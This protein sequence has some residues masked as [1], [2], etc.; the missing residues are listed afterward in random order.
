MVLMDLPGAQLE[1]SARLQDVIDA[2]R[3]TKK[4]GEITFTL[5]V[6]V[7]KVDAQTIELLPVVKTTIPKHAL[8]GGVF[9]ADD[10]GKPTKEDP[11]QLWRGDDIKSAPTFQASTEPIKEAP[12][13]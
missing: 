11:A 6:S 4:P 5:K 2:V 13:T 3:D 9:Y 1:A 7:G 12:T 8:K 10:N